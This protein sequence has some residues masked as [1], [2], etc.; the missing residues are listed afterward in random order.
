MND[1]KFWVIVVIMAMALCFGEK[2]ARA[3]NR[4]ERGEHVI[5]F[6]ICVLL[7]ILAQN[8]WHR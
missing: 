8:I 5:T 1:P 6:T 4:E 3:Q 7:A 2:A